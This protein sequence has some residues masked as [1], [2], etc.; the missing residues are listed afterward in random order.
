MTQ[1]SAA[2][3]RS[4]RPTWDSIAAHPLVSAVIAILVIATVFF[5]L[6]VPLYASVTPK[7]G[8]FPFFYFYLIVYMPVVGIVLGIVIWLQAKLRPAAAPGDEAGPG[9]GQVTR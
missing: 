6:Y 9:A 7:I 3:P 2:T 4:S 5:S 1:P 8:D